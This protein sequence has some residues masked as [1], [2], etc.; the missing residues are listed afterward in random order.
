[1]ATKWT[2]MSAGGWYYD[3]VLS[4]YVN[5]LTAAS[6]GLDNVIDVCLQQLVWCAVGSPCAMT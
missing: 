5:T 3:D 6:T 1:M 4:D 2:A